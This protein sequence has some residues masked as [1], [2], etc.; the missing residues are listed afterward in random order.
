MEFIIDLNTFRDTRLWS[1]SSD[2][3]MFHVLRAENL[4]AFFPISVLT[5]ET[6]MTKVLGAATV[7]PIIQD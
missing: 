1:L 5:L 6:E 4:K 3:K 2:C 7:G